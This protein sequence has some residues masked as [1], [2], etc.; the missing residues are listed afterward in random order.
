MFRK[1]DFPVQLV[2]ILFSIYLRGLIIIYNNKINF[3]MLMVS[4]VIISN[5]LTV[6]LEA[7]RERWREVGNPLFYN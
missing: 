2:A 5:E 7:G 6:R 4:S 3:I 1:A